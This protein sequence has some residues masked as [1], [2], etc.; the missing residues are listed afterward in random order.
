MRLIGCGRIRY[1]EDSKIILRGENTKKTKTKK[2][3][4]LI[5]GVVIKIKA[6]LRKIFM[7][8]KEII[9]VKFKGL[10]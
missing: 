6:S 8:M 2:I 3:T 5:K 10:W 7:R 1:R 4:L 9:Y